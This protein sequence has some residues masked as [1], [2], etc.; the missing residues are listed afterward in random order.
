MKYVR[1][2]FLLIA[3]S[4]ISYACSD[5]SDNQPATQNNGFY[6][7]GPI[8]FSFQNYGPTLSYTSSRIR[9]SYSFFPA[10]ETPDTK[11]LFVFFNGGPGCATCTGLLSL[12]TAPF[13]L[14]K[15]RTDSIKANPYSFTRLG[16]LLY[17]DAPNTGFSYNLVKYADNKDVRTAEF[18]ARNFNPFID[19]AQV[20]RVLLRF[21]ADRPAIESNPVI[22]VGESYGGTRAETMLNLLL[23]YTR[24]GDGSRIY[25]DDALSAEIQ[26][27]FEKIDPSCKGRTVPPEAVASQF[28]SQILIEPLLTGHYQDDL[29]G[30]AYEKEG[31]LIF[32][33]AQATG[34]TYTP[35]NGRPDCTAFDNALDYVE[36]TAKRDVY[37]YDMDDGYTMGISDYNRGMVDRG[38]ILSDIW[39]RDA[40]SI[41]LLKPSVRNNAYRYIESESRDAMAVLESVGFERLPAAE[42]MRIRKTVML[43]ALGSEGIR[44]KEATDTLEMLLGSL[45]PWDAYVVGCNDAVNNTYYNNRAID[46]GYPIDPMDETY[47]RLFLENLPLVDTFISDCDLD[48]VIYAAVLPDSIK[49]YTDIVEDVVWDDATDDGYIYV[50]YRPGSLPDMETPDMRPIYF[51]RYRASGHMVTLAQPDKFF[52]DVGRWLSG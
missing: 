10:D 41:R 15:N 26:N 20:T 23:F 11:P 14:D 49:E 18:E 28:G 39:G 31:S 38:S 12:N 37:Q 34:T 29:A 19:A 22:I 30:E 40:L 16:N 17:I 32:G 24:Y 50:Y 51:P 35:C 42:R 6:E 36:D 45:N 9:V 13:T 25:R 27:H 46:A 43:K 4:F 33:I 5:S 8:N 3:V 47:G 44:P 1:L 2:V 21:L 52:D 48:L 7:I